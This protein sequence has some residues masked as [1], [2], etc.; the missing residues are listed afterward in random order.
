MISLYIR[1]KFSTHYRFIFASFFYV[2]CFRVILLNYKNM[3]CRLLLR[4][5]GGLIPITTDV[6]HGEVVQSL[7]FVVLERP[8]P[9]I[10]EDLNGAVV[11]S[12]LK[13]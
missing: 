13:K 2:S 9:D 8:L 3:R 4:F 5:G 12:S 1:L 6:P 7:Q 11:I 10:K